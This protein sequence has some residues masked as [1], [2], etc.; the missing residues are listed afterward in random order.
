M[1]AGWVLV[2]LLCTLWP[3]TE[4]RAHHI[5]GRPSYSL[6]EDSNTPPS[7]QIETQIG[8]FFVNCMVYP[9]FPRPDEPGRVHFYA[10][11]IVGG[12]PF[13]GEV[14]FSIRDDTWFG[15][16]QE[17]IGRQPADETVFRQGFLITRP[18]DY[19][20]TAAFDY[21]GEPYR[22][23]FPMRVGDPSPVGPLGLTVAILALVLI[24]VNLI[25]RRR[26]LR[27]RIQMA[28]QD[29]QR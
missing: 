10:T 14:T 20:I 23:D 9:A 21:G 29:E 24:S 1:Q 15:G 27:S 12:V 18:G 3:L 22:I 7:M 17:V 26:L 2:V 5:L 13:A 28:H 11:T 16:E 4:A 8:E 25:Q 19:I 6:N